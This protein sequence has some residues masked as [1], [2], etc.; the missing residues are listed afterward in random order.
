MNNINVKSYKDS[1]IY[2]SD[3]E[4]FFQLS[5]NQLTLIARG[6]WS[7]SIDDAEVFSINRIKNHVPLD[8]E[9]YIFENIMDN[10]LNPK[11]I[12]C[13]P[14]GL[15]VKHVSKNKFKTFISDVHFDHAVT[16]LEL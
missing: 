4:E 1:V 14:V 15:S 9:Y 12:W 5:Y 8:S 6:F 13:V 16:I 2:N 7:R 11:V 10:K 3:T